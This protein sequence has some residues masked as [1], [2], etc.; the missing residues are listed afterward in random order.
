[1]YSTSPAV[2][3]EALGVVR[4][5]MAKSSSFVDSFRH[6]STLFGRLECPRIDKLDALDNHMNTQRADLLLALPRNSLP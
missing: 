4:H 2:F 5:N 3:D 1:M 6:R